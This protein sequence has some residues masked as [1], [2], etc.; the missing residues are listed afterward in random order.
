MLIWPVPNPKAQ[1]SGSSTAG[2]FPNTFTQSQGQT[3]LT[4]SVFC[5]VSFPKLQKEVS[6]SQTIGGPGEGDEKV[7]GPSLGY[8]GKPLQP[9][10][11][12]AWVIT[13]GYWLPRAILHFLDGSP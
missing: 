12:R 1:A 13:K 5:H 3:P 8:R 9:A 7:D 11:H 6:N 2:S 4:S 10:R